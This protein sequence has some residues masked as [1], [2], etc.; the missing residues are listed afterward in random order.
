MSNKQ[1]L[2]M[3]VTNE[4]SHTISQGVQMSELTTHTHTAIPVHKY[5]VAVMGEGCSGKSTFIQRCRTRKFTEEYNPSEGVM[6]T[7]LTF[8][9]TRGKV[10]LNVW[11]WPGQEQFGGLH[12]VS[13]VGA[14]A[15]ILMFDVT[16][17]DTYIKL[18]NWYYKLPYRMYTS[19]PKY[20]S[21]PVVICGTK[22]DLPDIIIKDENCKF[23]FNVNPKCEN[24][25]YF[26]ISSKTQVGMLD[27]L[28]C[29]IRQLLDDPE[30]EFIKEVI[31]DIA[32]AIKPLSTSITEE[33]ASN[34]IKDG[35]LVQKTEMCEHTCE[36]LCDEVFDYAINHTKDET[37]HI[38][39]HIST[40]LSRLHED[41]DLQY[42]D[43]NPKVDGLA[44]PCKEDF[45]LL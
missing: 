33:L 3:S 18:A 26:G 31:P 27:P 35:I 34:Q 17:F 36:Q 37:S 20:I 30:V 4:D 7:L 32:I 5:R 21:I 14:H 9:T 38:L 10:I 15:A 28:L 11:D 43:R 42:S 29:L 16:N 22:I 12:E 24:L 44:L 40:S 6:A 41:I 2:P 23:S 1:S 45:I 19:I 25:Q 39:K 13:C 8:N